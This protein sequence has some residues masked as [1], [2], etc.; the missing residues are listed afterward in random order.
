[1]SAIDIDTILAAVQPKAARAD[2]AGGQ[3]RSQGMMAPKGRG[4]FEA[5]LFWAFVGLAIIS[6]VV[7]L[8]LLVQVRGL[9][10]EIAILESEFGATNSRLDNLKRAVGRVSNAQSQV[11]GEF[12]N[13]RT[14]SPIVLSAEEIQLVH[15][16]IK[17]A[18]AKT[19]AQPM[20]KVG[21]E[22]AQVDS[23][24]VPDAMV[25]KLPKLRGA[26]FAFDKNGAIVIIG[27][28]NNRVDVVIAEVS[29][30]TLN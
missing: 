30:L 1:M 25:A 19:R 29:S 18:P 10:T 15:Q 22:V 27:L 24:P 8:V 16:F 17:A 21:D 12:K 14:E 13:A 28:R 4:T 23:F 2:Q 7:A 11:A 20:L 6:S 9:K 5:V 3:P 26:R